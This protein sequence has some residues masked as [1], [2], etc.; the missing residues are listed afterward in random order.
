M[1]KKNWIAALALALTLPDIC[2]RLEKPT[3]GS[4]KRFVAWW[5][6]YLLAKYTY[7]IGPKRV[8]HVFLAGNDAYALRCAVLHEGRD[9]V[10][11]Q[12]AKAA[13]E[14]FHFTVPPP[15]P[16]YVHC[17]QTGKILQL[18]IDTFCQ[19]I[20]ESASRWIGD[21]QND[22]DIKARSGTLLT[23]YDL[24]GSLLQRL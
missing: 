12:R 20:C 15:P 24:S 23:V 11:T 6:K 1:N 7:L 2:G 19:D 21:T 14:K 16:A 18:Q 22:V 4:E 13:L 5:D 9:E 3:K 8:K 17:N 10:L